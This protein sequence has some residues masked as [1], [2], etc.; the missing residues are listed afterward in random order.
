MKLK[1]DENGHV[2]VE[3]G[4]PVYVHEDGK[5]IPFDATKATAKSQSL[6]VRRKNTVKPKSRRRQNSRHFRGLTIR[7]QQSKPWKR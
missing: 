2:V 5:E 4:M 6:T 3:N 1:L 7:K